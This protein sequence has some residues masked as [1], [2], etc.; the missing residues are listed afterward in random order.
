MFKRIEK[1]RR[2]KIEE[3]ELGLDENMKEILGMHDTDS[4]ESDSDSDQTSAA[5]VEEEPE[6]DISDTGGFGER[7]EDED[8]EEHLITVQEA[9]RDPVYLVSLQPDV[10]ACIVC[11]RKLL[12]GPKMVELHRTSKAHE[13]RVKQFRMMTVEVNSKE[14]AS[15]IIRQSNEGHPKLTLT[16]SENSKRGEKRKAKLAAHQAKRAKQ[17]AKRKAKK[18]A[19]DNTKSDAVSD[20][21]TTDTQRSPELTVPLKK[22]K[23]GTSAPPLTASSKSEMPDSSESFNDDK[24]TQLTIKSIVRS[25]SERA[26]QARARFL[27]S[28]RDSQN[29]P[30]HKNRSKKSLL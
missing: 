19:A 15:R 27:K 28:S 3:D 12:K 25:T 6:E 23:I 2:K 9:L 8:E 21:A 16:P 13:R 14:S 11:P 1:R 17:K 18:A 29:P 30:H 10:K 20:V 26:K 5:G 22:R 4:D 7:L 24:S